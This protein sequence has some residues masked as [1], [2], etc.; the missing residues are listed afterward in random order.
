M[1]SIASGL[2]IYFE[3][4]SFE[5]TLFHAQSGAKLR[6]WVFVRILTGCVYDRRRRARG[7]SVARG[8][9]SGRCCRSLHRIMGA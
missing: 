9:A 3:S 8:P 5:A 4:A 6:L 1:I 7:Y 2:S